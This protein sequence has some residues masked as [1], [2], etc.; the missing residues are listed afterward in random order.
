MPPPAQRHPSSGYI[1]AACAALLFASKGLFVKALA[2][3]G[4][5]YLT[6]TLV[7]SVLALPLFAALA[8]WRGVDLRRAPPRVLALAALAGSLG[9]GVGAL[10]D[11]RALEMIDV[12]VERALLFTYPAMIVGW[13]ALARRQLPRPA[14]LLALLATYSGILL[15]VGGFDVALWKQNLFGAL[16]V[17]TCSACMACYFLIGER[18]I[19]VLG[20]SGFTLAA[21]GAATGF[22]L[23]AFIGSRPLA[24]VTALDGR[25]WL[26]MVALAVLCM[27]LPAM[28]Q[29]TAISRIG[30]E[31]GALAS[32][33]GPPAALVLGM[34][35]LGERPDIW[36]LLGTAMIVA[37]IVLI[38]RDDSPPGRN[39]PRQSAAE[40]PPA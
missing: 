27:F 16:L 14:V 21:L 19:A 39:L 32:T 26:L 33:I 11:F 34:L 28:F 17:L 37:S 18:A 6:M 24:A 15:V 3:R 4:V 5:D 1:F 20:S 29:A 36:Q 2:A 25:D 7:R 40:E 9:Y 30:A 23:V 10:V 8:L 12:S 31:R 22:V 35:L 38:A 13:Q